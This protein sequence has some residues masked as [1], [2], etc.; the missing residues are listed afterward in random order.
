MV[1]QSDSG[2]DLKTRLLVLG[3]LTFRR[4]FQTI[5]RAYLRLRRM[6]RTEGT[7]HVRPS[8]L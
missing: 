1:T 5:L 3:T 2:R 8:V 7:H 4:V 6:W